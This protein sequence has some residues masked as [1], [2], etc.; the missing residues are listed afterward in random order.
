MTAK[1]IQETATISS[2]HRDD[3]EARFCC[4]LRDQ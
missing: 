3:R 2:K 4:I 1:T